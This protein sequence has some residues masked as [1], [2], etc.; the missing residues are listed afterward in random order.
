[1]AIQIAFQ[2]DHWV[3]DVNPVYLDDGLKVALSE[4]MG[5]RSIRNLETS[6]NLT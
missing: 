4:L 3:I 5:I 1:M 6:H 2:W